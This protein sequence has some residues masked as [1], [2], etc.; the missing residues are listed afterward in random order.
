VV[1]TD[2]ELDDAEAARALP[3]GSRIVVVPHR[4]Q[5]DLAVSSIDIPRA[6]VSGDS[7]EARI[8]L[9]AGGT[10]ARAGTLALT[11]DGKQIGS[12][13][14]DSLGAFAERTVSI[15]TKL[16]APA[17]S[18]VLRAIVASAEDAER[19]NDTL[20]VAIDVSRAATAVFVSTS[21]DF[22]ARYSLAVLRGS[23]GIPTRGFFRV[24]PGE[25]RV[26]GALTPIAEA[27]VRQALREAPVAII[28]GDTAAFGAPRAATLGPLALIAPV[29]AEGEW[30]ASAAPASPLTPSLSGVVWDSLPPVAVAPS[31]PAGSWQGVEVRRGRGEEKKA[32]VVGSDE[33]RRVAVIAA[34]GLWRWRFRGGVA[35]DA[36]T[37]L[38]GGIFD[39]LAAQ[40]ADRRAAVPDERMLRAGDPIRWRRGSPT[41]S[42]VAVALRLRPDGVAKGNAGSR[43]DSL[44]LRFPSDVNV[45]ESKPLAP[46]IYEVST[47]GGTSLLAV[48]PSREWLPRAP[49]VV[50]GAV[51][52]SVSADS[53]PRLR[54]QWWAY[55]LAMLLLCG[56]WI[57]R[58]RRGM[59]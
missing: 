24:A 18:S 32:I 4:P 53:A 41:D 47:R 58:R 7:V 57:I 48:N 39:W 34:S 28:H 12:A 16:D 9:A 54:D 13:P 59:R 49:R 23:L 2:G 22:D 33:P 44:T 50:S 26:E 56:E 10:G 45:V 6:V 29:G 25:W 21:P 38:W 27:D 19:R 43:T 35:S 52:G 46:G 42:L 8:S 11:L 3:G 37:A 30:Y 5:R 14:V 31:V 55:A 1:V 36:Y 40:R 17:G 15:K 20:S 51:R